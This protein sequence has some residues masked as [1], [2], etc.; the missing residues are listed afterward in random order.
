MW[1][2]VPDFPYEVSDAGEVRRVGSVRTLRA[3]PAKRGGYLQVSLWTDGK[4]HTRMVHQLVALAFHGQRPS[5][6]HHAAH[7]DGN[8]AN[9]S[10]TNIEWLTR[11]ENE[12]D[13]I[14]HGT[15]NRGERN[16]SAKI[17]DSVIAEILAAPR[18]R[19]YQTRLAEKHGVTQ[20]AISNIIR[21][22]R[23]S[24]ECSR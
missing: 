15:S 20:G 5:P 22:K 14:A 11:V 8:K 16:G 1:R 3:T 17:A 13:K 18:P 7:R 9:N 19:G 21:G 6:D 2:P 24:Y 12:A 10:T 23:R 4:G